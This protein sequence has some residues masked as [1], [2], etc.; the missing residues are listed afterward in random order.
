MYILNIN[1]TVGYVHCVYN[2]Q[3]YAHIYKLY[4]ILHGTAYIKHVYAFT[5]L[6]IH[7]DA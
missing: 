2:K 7:G 5:A 6:L 4:A 1:A 3:M